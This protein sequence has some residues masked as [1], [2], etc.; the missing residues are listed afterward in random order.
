MAGQQQQQVSTQR[1]A[2]AKDSAAPAGAVSAQSRY[3]NAYLQDQVR[4]KQGMGQM[5]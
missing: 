5:T 3:G 2:P 1:A 4:E